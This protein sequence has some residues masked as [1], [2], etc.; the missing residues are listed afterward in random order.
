[1][2]PFS[3]FFAR[4]VDELGPF[5]AAA[6]IHEFEG[7]TLAFPAVTTSQ[8][9]SEE[10]DIATKHTLGFP[11]LRANGKHIFSRAR[12]KSFFEAC[13]RDPTIKARN[14]AICRSFNGHNHAELA[15]EFRL[16]LRAT[17]HI[18]KRA[19]HNPEETP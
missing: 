3:L 1:M 17:Y 6:L 11:R 19:Q 9:I 8:T 15:R 12:I 4:L 5:K 7:Q 2:S 13:D 10:T 18:I 14:R 16:S